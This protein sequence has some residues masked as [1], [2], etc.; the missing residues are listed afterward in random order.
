[1]DTSV[2]F[3]AEM[4]EYSNFADCYTIDVRISESGSLAKKKMVCQPD[5]KDN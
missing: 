2:S 4:K 3:A 5:F 1:M